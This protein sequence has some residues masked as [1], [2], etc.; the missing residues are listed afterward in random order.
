MAFSQ[1]DLFWGMGSGFV[2]ATT[3]LAAHV[4]CREGERLFDIGDPADRFYVLLKGS[5]T[6]KRGD[7]ELHTAEKAGEIFGWSSL[8]SRPEYAAS[9]TCDK[10]TELLRIESGPFLKIL[11]ESPGDK[12]ILFERLAKMLGNQLLGVYI[13]ANE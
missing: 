9:A 8:I 1:S 7:G 12:A 10:K 6:M 13:S 2:K 4:T 3:E 11:N 5:V